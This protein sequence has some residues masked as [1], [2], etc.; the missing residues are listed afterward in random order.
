METLKMAANRK[1]GCYFGIYN[2]NGIYKLPPDIEIVD[3]L[4]K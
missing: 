4:T 1:R 2:K 3:N